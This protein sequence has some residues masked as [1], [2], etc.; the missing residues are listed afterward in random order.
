MEQP[1]TVNG[2]SLRSSN[3]TR[4][5]KAIYFSDASIMYG[6]FTLYIYQIFTNYLRFI[7]HKCTMVHH[8]LVIYIADN[9]KGE[10]AQQQQ[11]SISDIYIYFDQ[12]MSAKPW[13][14]W[15]CEAP[16]TTI[17]D[18]SYRGG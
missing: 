13:D 9:L 14:W 12:Y 4:V 3:K 7:Y 18:P 5:I 2:I 10:C 6:R 1:N 17:E 11:C 15:I 16:G 8:L